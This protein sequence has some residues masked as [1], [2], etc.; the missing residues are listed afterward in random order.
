MATAVIESEPKPKRYAKLA[1]GEFERIQELILD[2]LAKSESGMSQLLEDVRIWRALYRGET[3]IKNR[4]WENCSNVPPSMI[5][6]KILDMT[7]QITRSVFTVSPIIGVEGTSPKAKDAAPRMEQFTDYWTTEL[8]LPSLGYQITD[9]ALI[10]G[11]AHLAVTME[12]T[13]KRLPAK[14]KQPD[15]MA[16]LLQSIINGQSPEQPVHVDK[17][18][19]R[20]SFEVVKIE[21][22][23]LCPCDAPSYRQA[24]G[25]F[26]R[27]YVR[28]EDLR[29]GE[30]RGWYDLEDVEQQWQ[31]FVKS[32][33]TRTAA[34]EEAEI[35]SGISEQCPEDLQGAVLVGWE[36]TWK[37][38]PAESE[39][40]MTFIVV[41]LPEI[42]RVIRFQPFPYKHNLPMMARFRILPVTGSYFGESYV[43]VMRGPQ[44]EK[45]TLTNMIIDGLTLQ[46]I[47]PVKR[48]AGRSG[49]ATTELIPGAEWSLMDLNDAQPI[50]L[51]QLPTAEVFRYL[52][53][54][55][56]DEERLTGSTD[57]TTG[58]QAPS[59]H[60]LG[61]LNL[62][63]DQ[64]GQ[65]NEV[66]VM[67]FEEGSEP[68][69][70]VTGI[71]DRLFPLFRQFYGSMDD[72]I[73][74]AVTGAADGLFPRVAPEDFS[75]EYSFVARG[76]SVTANP[77]LRYQQ[78][79]MVSQFVGASIFSNPKA[80]GEWLQGCITGGMQPDDILEYMRRQYASARRLLESAKVRDPETY[81]G[82]EPD[83][84]YVQ[85]S[86]EGLAKTMAAMVNAR[87]GGGGTA[88][89]DGP[90][91]PGV[92][93]P[94]G[95][96]PAG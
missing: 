90:P 73:V 75:A 96:I 58:R 28:W 13:G 76:N 91:Q 55:R 42:N 46:I 36:G 1:P 43:E 45:T 31:S 30:K 77:Q 38:R 87:G 5:R 68:G 95:Q 59:G 24:Q 35:A 64:G 7:A 41:A 17:L 16:T 57:L 19:M 21:D 6:E 27:I 88:P 70:G 15:D 18:D 84:A 44:T 94:A 12:P 20:P 22:V 29:A 10:T 32:G 4:P 66:R 86:L 83:E 80:R 48:R 37:Y 67:I 82:K 54:Q 26:R 40:E 49:E 52:Q 93:A 34:Q 60:T 47:P 25:L 74:F 72:P 92:D 33:A 78:A 14:Q 63:M 69:D 50:Q 71:A 85:K 8:K 11:T 81:I 53:D 56:A 79:G 51:P 39:K 61:E 2:S 89:T 9:E 62:A 23:R 65:R 3:T